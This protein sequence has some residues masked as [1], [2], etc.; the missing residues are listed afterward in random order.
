VPL[1]IVPGNH[2]RSRI[3]QHLWTAHPNIRIFD[4]P[5]TN[6]LSLPTGSMALA[7]FPYHREGRARFR[8]LVKQ[9]GYRTVVADAH[10]LCVHQVVEGAQVGVSNYTFRSGPH[11]VRGCD[12]PEGFAAVLSGHIHRAQM[13]TRDLTGR[14]LAAP[15]IY[16]GSV[17]RTS[18]VERDEE[19]NYVILTVDLTGQGGGALLDAAFVPLPARPMVNLVLDL[20]RLGGQSPAEHL[21][22]RLLVLAP[23]AVV[24]VQLEGSDGAGARQT[25]SAACLRELAP[26]SM[27]VTL[28]PDRRG[29]RTRPRH[30]G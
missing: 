17:E 19:K 3:P 7:G 26:P 29:Y 9:T 13:L 6:T 16:P 15:V 18:F 30:R 5:R 22:K 11:V 24:R 10:L 2:E 12:I 28:A 25:L 20:D 23:D 27:N 1:Y 14:P 4:E 8:Q 21:R